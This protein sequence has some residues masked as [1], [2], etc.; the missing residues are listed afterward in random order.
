MIPDKVAPAIS[1]RPFCRRGSYLLAGAAAHDG[2][3][4][5]WV[6]PG[7]S[8]GRIAPAARDFASKRKSRLCRKGFTK[9][10]KF[11]RREAGNNARLILSW[12]SYSVCNDNPQRRVETKSKAAILH[13]KRPFIAGMG[14]RMDKGIRQ[15]ENDKHVLKILT[16]AQKITNINDI[17]FLIRRFTEWVNFPVPHSRIEND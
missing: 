7:S 14:D 15:L 5:V 16:E 13:I 4:Y 8:H 3:F 12:A 11:E 2:L 1:T 17:R 9:S 10:E 6:A